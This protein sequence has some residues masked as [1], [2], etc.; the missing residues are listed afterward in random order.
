MKLRMEI[1]PAT[2]EEMEKLL[3]DFASY[4]PAVIAK[5]KAAIGN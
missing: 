5:A 2:A 3:A 1:N 4:P